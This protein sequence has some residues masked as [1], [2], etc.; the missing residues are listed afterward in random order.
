VAIL[1]ALMSSLVWG[2]SDFVGGLMS[3]RSPVRM[4][5]VTSQAAGFAA[6]TLV[7]VITGG[8]GHALSWVGPALI[9][10]AGLAAGLVMFYAALASGAMGVVSPIAALGVLVPVTVGATQGDSLTA[11]TTIGIVLAL[12][13]VVAASGPEFRVDAHARSILLAGASAICFGVALLFLAEGAQADPVMSLWG[14]RATSVIGLGTTIFITTRHR[15]TPLSIRRRDV[16]LVMLAGVGDSAANLLY[17]LA[18]LRGY[19]SVV[20]V[21]ASLYPAV[22]AMLAWAVLHQKLRRAQLAGV[23]AALAGVAL[24]SMGG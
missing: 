23:I 12:G 14:M 8:F 1:L 11:T 16:P 24:V 18:S 13:G 6:V 5:V 10:G 15:V 20:S 7:A 21:L 2:T 3:R 22:T 9:A 17:Q 4:V 19:L